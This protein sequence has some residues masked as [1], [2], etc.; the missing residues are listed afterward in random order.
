MDSTV[1]DQP[2][3][4]GAVALTTTGERLG[5]VGDVDHTPDSD[6][7]SPPTVQ[8]RRAGESRRRR[9]RRSW[10]VD[11]HFSRDTALDRPMRLS[12]GIEVETVQRE[13]GNLTN[14]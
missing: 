7:C 8:R 12:C 2:T 10:D 13:P 9:P 1:P 11:E 14:R 3:L 6:G 5:L 4:L